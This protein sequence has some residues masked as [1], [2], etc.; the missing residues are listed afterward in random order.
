[1]GWHSATATSTGPVHRSAI[2]GEMHNMVKSRKLPIVGDGAG[3]WSFVHVD[4]AASATV[5]AL[6]TGVEGVYNIVDDDP[7]PVADWLPY[8]A[9]SIGAKPPRHVPKWLARPLIGEL[10]IRFMTEIRGATNTKAR[11]E[12]EWRLLYPSWRT[13]FANA[14]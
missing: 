7:A 2:G 8:L 13:G 14:R 9:K 6:D 12:L 4:D 1:M 11:S 10:G 5:Q 3:V